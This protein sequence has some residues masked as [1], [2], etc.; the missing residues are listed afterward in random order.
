MRFKI[1]VLHKAYKQVFKQLYTSLCQDLQKQEWI[2]TKR[3]Q[4]DNKQV[5]MSYDRHEVNKEVTQA[6]TSIRLLS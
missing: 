1:R 4:Q 2:L 3:P 6:T 5:A